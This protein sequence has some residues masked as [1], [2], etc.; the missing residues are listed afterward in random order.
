MGQE[1][2]KYCRHVRS[3]SL[4]LI[5]SKTTYQ[6]ENGSTFTDLPARVYGNQS[7]KISKSATLISY[8][9]PCMNHVS[10][11]N[12]KTWLSDWIIGESYQAPTFFPSAPA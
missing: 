3:L 1:W 9:Q 2:E 10:N 7:S 8:G 6:D 5:F 12:F 4:N 11:R